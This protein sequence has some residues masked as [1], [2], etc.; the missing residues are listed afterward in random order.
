MRALATTAVSLVMLSASTLAV[1][2]QQGLSRF[3][4]V[5]NQV[6]VR[7]VRPDSTVMRPPAQGVSIIHNGHFVQLWIAPA[8]CPDMILEHR[9]LGLPAYQDDLVDL[10]PSQA[11]F[12]DGVL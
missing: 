5:W 8:Q 4:G 2:A 10:L 12:L 6:E 3:D 1:S 7:V 11:S 9:E